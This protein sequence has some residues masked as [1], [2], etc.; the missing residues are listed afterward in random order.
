M[1]ALSTLG[2][3]LT[4]STA[5]D[6]FP[7]A[8]NGST[9]FALVASNTLNKDN[10]QH[11]FAYGGGFNISGAAV[12][13]ASLPTHSWEYGAATMA[14]LELYTPWASV[15][16]M[17]PG[18]WDV[19]VNVNTVSFP[20]SHCFITNYNTPLPVFPTDPRRIFSANMDRS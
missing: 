20:P 12:L 16:G 15:Y 9:S 1:N 18:A 2:A 3:L 5:F 13:C 6:P 17:K 11:S 10:V 14:L 8:T 4:S 19:A 7:F